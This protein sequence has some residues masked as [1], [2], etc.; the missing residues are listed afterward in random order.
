MRGNFSLWYLF[1]VVRQAKGGE[2]GFYDKSFCLPRWIRLL[3]DGLINDCLSLI[4]LHASGHPALRGG[5]GGLTSLLSITFPSSGLVAWVASGVVS[6]AEVV[7]VLLEVWVASRVAVSLGP[8]EPK[9]PVVSVVGTAQRTF[10]VP[11]LFLPL[12]FSF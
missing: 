9:G 1:P 10:L 12:N 7:W 2:K 6:V 5:G 8:V 3:Y 4:W 11:I